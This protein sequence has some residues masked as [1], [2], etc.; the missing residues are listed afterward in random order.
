MLHDYVINKTKIEVFNSKF[1]KHCSEFGIKYS[2]TKNLA[3][4]FN[5]HPNNIA[6]L[7]LDER[8]VFEINVD[9][10]QN[11]TNLTSLSMKGHSLGREENKKIMLH[12]LKSNTN[13]KFLWVDYDAEA[14]FFEMYRGKEM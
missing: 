2:Q 7:N 8:N 12:I 6:S 11:F 1:T 14:N 5:E 4:T 9:V 3:D 10:L 13:L